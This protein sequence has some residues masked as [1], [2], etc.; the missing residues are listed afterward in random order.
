MHY[1]LC[2][3]VNHSC[4]SFRSVYRYTIYSRFSISI[5]CCGFAPWSVQNINKLVAYLFV[6][7]QY[8]SI[9]IREHGQPW[10]TL[11]TDVPLPAMNV[12]NSRPSES[13]YSTVATCEHL[14]EIMIST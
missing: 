9:S 3:E 14:I 7:V 10:T 1:N 8:N 12:N 6:H 13:K 2:P 11:S 5:L 4:S